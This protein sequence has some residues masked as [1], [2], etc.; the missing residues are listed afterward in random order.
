MNNLNRLTENNKKTY[1]N[2]LKTSGSNNFNKIKNAAYDTHRIREFRT[3]LGK[4]NINALSTNQL[5]KYEQQ[6][7]KGGKL[8]NIFNN[9]KRAAQRNGVTTRGAKRARTRENLSRV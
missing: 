7:R 8:Q 4:N 9:A 6:I 1:L 5:T 2:Q 3:L